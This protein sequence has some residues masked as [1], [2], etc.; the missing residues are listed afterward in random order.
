MVP[1]VYTSL[2][3]RLPLAWNTFWPR[4]TSMWSQ[5]SRRWY[6]WGWDYDPSD[7]A[8]ALNTHLE[9]LRIQKSVLQCVR[10]AFRSAFFDSYLFLCQVFVC[11]AIYYNL[12]TDCGTNSNA[13]QILQAWP[14][15][16]MA[17]KWPG[18]VWIGS[19]LDGCDVYKQSSPTVPPSARK[20]VPPAIYLPV[21]SASCNFSCDSSQEISP[22]FAWVHGSIV[23][24]FWAWSSPNSDV[25]FF[26]LKRV[27]DS[28]KHENKLMFSIK[29]TKDKWWSRICRGSKSVNHIA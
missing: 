28:I 5:K 12:S 15:R 17:C 25:V 10:S 18:I 21:E 11:L 29:L 16:S 8:N 6:G 24:T 4:P 22:E 14:Q 19:R 23:L 13:L 2:R 26:G 20:C 1:K 27:W 7:L 3:L 9:W